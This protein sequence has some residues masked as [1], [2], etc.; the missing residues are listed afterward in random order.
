DL[1]GVATT[2]VASFTAERPL[3]PTAATEIVGAGDNVLVTGSSL[4]VSTPGYDGDQPVTGIHRF[5]IADL[6][7]TGS[8]SV[9]GRLLNQ[10]SLDEHDGHLRAAITT[11]DGSFGR[12]MPIDGG[13]AVPDVGVAV[14]PAAPSVAPGSSGDIDATPTTSPDAATSTIV[15]D[16]ASATAGVTEPAP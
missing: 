9:E 1:G 16:G 14:D 13:V 6:T 10:F 11:Q 8:G 12:P 2:L 3:E 15:D 7:H 5:D 4:Y